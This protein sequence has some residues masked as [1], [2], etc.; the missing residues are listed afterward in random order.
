MQPAVRHQ[1]L[2]RKRGDSPGREIAEKIGRKKELLCSVGTIRKPR[3]IQEW[4][5]EQQA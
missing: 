4:H 2:V 5:S 1:L 3:H